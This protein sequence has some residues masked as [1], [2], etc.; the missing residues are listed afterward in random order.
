MADILPGFVSMA[1]DP[2]ERSEDTPAVADTSAMPVYPYGLSICLQEEQ[3]A[4][5]DLEDDVEVGNMIALHCLAKVTSVAKNDTTDG[6]KTRVE[7]QI[8][9]IEAEENEEE[10]TRP[11]VAEQYGKRYKKGE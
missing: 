2:K 4:K 7:M 10:D 11:S 9:A 1:L 3:L 6:T 5:L 8:V